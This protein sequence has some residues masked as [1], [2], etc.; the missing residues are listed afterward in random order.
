MG[1]FL[2]FSLGIRA[3]KIMGFFFVLL[4]DFSSFSNQNPLLV[5]P[6]IVQLEVSLF[7]SFFWVYSAAQQRERER[8]IWKLFLKGDNPYGFSAEIESHDF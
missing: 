3:R 4:S 7:P 5:E 2:T 1:D 8:V 6:I